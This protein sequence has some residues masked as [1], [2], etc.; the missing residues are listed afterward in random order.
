MGLIFLFFFYLAIIFVCIAALW[1]IFEKV[2]KPGWVAIIPFY[3]TY[4]LI[5]IIGRPGWW[6]LL[7]F[8]PLVN[9]VISFIIS[10][11]IARC[12]GKDFGFGVGLAFL[13]FIFL[14][15]LAFGDAKFTGK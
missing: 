4:V 5:Q 6:F 14:P 3:N 11:D 12:F 7:M 10:I 1:K 13:P 9:I 15:I 8:I 2:G